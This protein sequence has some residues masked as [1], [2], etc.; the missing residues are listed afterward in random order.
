[1]INLQCIHLFSSQ[2]LPILAL[3]P[4]P[5]FRL[6]PRL[7][8]S[9]PLSLILP[10]LFP[11]PALT[12]LPLAFFPTF[13]YSVHSLC[14]PV[15]PRWSPVAPISPLNF[16]RPSGDAGFHLNSDLQL[17]ATHGFA[18][19]AHYF[20]YS[21]SSFFLP[22]PIPPSVFA[23]TLQSFSHTAQFPPPDRKHAIVALSTTWYRVMV[24]PRETWE[25]PSLVLFFT[26][27][28]PVLRVWNA[29]PV[30]WFCPTV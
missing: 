9:L 6:S 22:F 10:H 11:F 1:M 17:L 20:F 24:S 2:C 8:L 21:H 15:S 29:S 18:F 25:D 13:I 19:T 3:P 16:H 23:L 26:V 28:N 30:L 12:P 7:S 27:S 5:L 4:Q 14:H